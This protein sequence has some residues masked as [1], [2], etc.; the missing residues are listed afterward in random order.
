M[1]HRASKL[2]TA[3]KYTMFICYTCPLWRSRRLIC[4]SLYASGWRVSPIVTAIVFQ[5]ARGAA[6]EMEV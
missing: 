3:V 6:Q 5:N 2:Y 4:R 1:S